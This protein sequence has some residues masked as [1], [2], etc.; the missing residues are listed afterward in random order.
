MS[1]VTPLVLLGCKAG[2]RDCSTVL[3]L[4]PTCSTNPPANLTSVLQRQPYLP[5]GNK[6][7]TREQLH[8]FFLHGRQNPEVV[9]FQENELFSSVLRKERNGG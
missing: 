5:T 7:G 2:P 6:C 1:G 9:E 8:S 4:G 3:L